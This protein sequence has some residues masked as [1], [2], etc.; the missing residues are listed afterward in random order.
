MC[1]YDNANTCAYPDVHTDELTHGSRPSPL[2]RAGLRTT[3]ASPSPAFL[4]RCD[5]PSGCVGRA[6]GVLRDPRPTGAVDRDLAGRLRT[7]LDPVGLDLAG[8]PRTPPDPARRRLPPAGDRVGSVRAR[9]RCDS[10][11]PIRSARQCSFCCS[12]L[13]KVP[14]FRTQRIATLCCPKTKPIAREHTIFNHNVM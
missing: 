9:Y 13:L 14:T 11:Q 2:S 6:A 10:I 4:V 12:I 5:R 7:S 8:G 3:P 1:L